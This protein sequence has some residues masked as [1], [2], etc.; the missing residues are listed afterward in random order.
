[1]A[2]SA[3]TAAVT[4]IVRR[5]PIS[6]ISTT[7]GRNVP[8]IAPAV[9]SA[10]IRPAISPARS[11]ESTPSRTANGEAIPSSVIGTENSAIEAKNEP[12]KAP[13]EASA[14]ALT[15]ADSSGSA[16]KGMIAIAIAAHSISRAHVA[17]AGVAVGQPAAPEVA[18]PR[19]RSGSGR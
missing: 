18:R 10:Y 13:T 3:S 1:M 9:E 19:G 7:T 17:Q 12:R 11:T 2:A 14:N 5:V 4:S 8:R 16:M 6:G 15:A